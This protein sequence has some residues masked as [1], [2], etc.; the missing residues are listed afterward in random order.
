[1]TCAF[2]SRLLVEGRAEIALPNTDQLEITP[3]GFFQGS[4][5]VKIA[6]IS[7]RFEGDLIA[8]DRPVLLMEIEEAHTRQP[9]EE[10]LGAVLALDY[11]GF[12]L[13][14]GELTS[15]DNFDGDA[16]HRAAPMSEDY[17]FNFI[18]KPKK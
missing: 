8:R 15:L 3:S 14:R 18:F 13:R 4:A 17:V 7:G 10:S 2:A 6:D 12:F 1:M 16:H 11:D 9:I 5:D